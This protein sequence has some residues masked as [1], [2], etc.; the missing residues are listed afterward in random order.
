MVPLETVT[1]K[2]KIDKSYDVTDFICSQRLLIL[3]SYNYF[4]SHQL[5][6]GLR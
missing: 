5:N 1:A 4:C 3:V 2:N 6:L